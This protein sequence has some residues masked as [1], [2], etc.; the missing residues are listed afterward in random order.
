MHYRWP[1]ESV[2]CGSFSGRSTGESP[3]NCFLSELSV[4]TTLS[5]DGTTVKCFFSN[6]LQLFLKGSSTLQVTGYRCILAQD[7]QNCVATHILTYYAGLC[8]YILHYCFVNCHSQAV[9]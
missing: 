9:Y 3:N 2:A 1:Q 5:L 4:N 7:S 6:G 8:K